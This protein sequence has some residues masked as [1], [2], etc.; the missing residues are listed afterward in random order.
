M[1]KLGI[2]YLAMA[3]VLAWSCSDA[4]AYYL[5]TATRCPT[6]DL[7][8]EF[9]LKM[10]NQ[11]DI[12][13]CYAHAAS[14]YLQFQFKVEDQISA[15]DVA[16]RYN[17]RPWPRL[18][19]WLT[20]NTVPQ[21]GFIR[22]SII[23]AVNE[24]YCPESVFPSES[25]TRVDQAG[26]ATQVN[27]KAAIEDLFRLQENIHHGIFKNASELPYSYVFK[28]VSKETLFDI[29][30]HSTSKQMLNEL[31]ITACEKDRKPFNGSIN[32]IGMHFR[33]RNVFNRINDQ[34]DSKQA[35]TI[36][37]FY[38]VLNNATHFKRGLGELHTTLLYGRRFDETTSECQ[39]LIKNSYGSD[40]TEYDS[41]HTCEGGYV[42]MN[43]SYLYR[44]LTSYVYFS[45]SHLDE[46]NGSQIQ[47]DQDD[48]SSEDVPEVT[49]SSEPV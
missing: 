10:R 7:R 20:G 1:A 17:L 18:A 6:V 3:I 31:R 34:L 5:T 32:Q 48:E 21:T 9:S 49:S 39:Y 47:G 8:N 23:D 29:L 26:V 12:S 35:L 37:F 45:Q 36:D 28:T 11:G 46:S 25:W 14:D 30:N 40:C 13:W 33:G 22:N 4:S 24:G 43:E 41:R 44:A 15:A 19:R 42:W 27:L 16:I 38:G 2:N